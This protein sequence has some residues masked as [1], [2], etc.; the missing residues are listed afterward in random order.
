M[1]TA[2]CQHIWTAYSIWSTNGAWLVWR[3]IKC[4]RGRDA[5]R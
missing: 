1:P 3:C 4:G 2:E 5:D